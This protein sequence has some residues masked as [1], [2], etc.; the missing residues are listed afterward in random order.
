MNLLKIPL[1]TEDYNFLFAF[2]TFRITIT[3]MF[4]FLFKGYY[5]ELNSSVKAIS[6]LLKRYIQALVPCCKL[7]LKQGYE[8][9]LNQSVSFTR[10]ASFLLLSVPGVILREFLVLLT[11]A[12]NFAPAV[13]STSEGI[14]LLG[15]LLDSLDTFNRSSKNWQADDADDLSWSSQGQFNFVDF[16]SFQVMTCKQVASK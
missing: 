13:A 12:Q 2:S 8:K 3:N 4:L 5:S 16:I 11:M 6:I 7:L 15:E 9:V 10:M 14:P 1:F